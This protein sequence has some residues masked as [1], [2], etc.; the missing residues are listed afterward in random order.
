[1]FSDMCKSL[2]QTHYATLF[3]AIYNPS[4]YQRKPMKVNF[5]LLGIS[6]NWLEQ[7]E[8]AGECFL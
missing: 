6:N 8:N 4:S 7:A 1:M 3:R 2:Q 5:D